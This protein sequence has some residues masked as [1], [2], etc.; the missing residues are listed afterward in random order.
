MKDIKEFQ[1]KSYFSK[2]AL[3]QMEREESQIKV[4]EQHRLHWFTLHLQR[5][6]LDHDLQPKMAEM[7]KD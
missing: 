3:G 7:P 2:T 5:V 1:G 6:K 4:L